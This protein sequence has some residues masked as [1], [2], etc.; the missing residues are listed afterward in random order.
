MKH[1]KTFFNG[2]WEEDHQ[3]QRVATNSTVYTPTALQGLFRFFP[4]AQNENITGAAPTVTTGGTPLQPARQPG[5][6][7]RQRIRQGPESPR[8]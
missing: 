7:N 3:N 2:I 5:R 8:T 4:G 6:S 1:N